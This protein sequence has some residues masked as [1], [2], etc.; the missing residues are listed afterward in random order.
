LSS[1]PRATDPTHRTARFHHLFRRIFSFPAMLACL[2]AMLATLTVR[3]RFND[4]D[5]WWQLK[6][7]EIIWTTHTVPTTDLF[8]Y[9]T[10]H[11]TWVPHEWLSQL[12][13]YGA[14]RWGGYSGL[15][16]WL[17]FFAAALLIAGYTLCSLY[18]GNSKTAFIGAL[19]IWLF[20][21]TV[22]AIRP[23]LVGYL[24]LVFELILV[25]LGRT[26][27]PRW[28]FGL[29]PLFA[30]WV[31]CHGSFFLGLLLLGLFLFCSFFDLRVGLLVSSR[32]D[33]RRRRT[34]VWALLLSTAALFL[35]PVGV[36]Q[37]LYPLNT[38]LRQH[39]V[40]SQISEW[41][42]L[43]YNDPRGAAL[44]AVLGCIFLLVIVRRAELFWQELLMLIMGT[45]LGI[46]HQRLA[47]VFGLLA[48]PIVSR[49]ISTSR[50]SYS[51]EQ[52][53]P[54]PNAVLIT[55]A[56]AT[57]IFTFPSQK[58]LQ[59]QV[60]DGNPVKAVE[61]IKTRHLS[62][63]MLN[64]FDYGGYL[65]WAL[66]EQPVFVDGRA[67]VYEWSGVLEEFAKWATLQSDS[68]ALLDKYG[69]DFCLLERGSLMANVM[70][71][72]PNWKVIYTDDVSV[73]FVRSAK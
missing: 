2:L 65:I 5:T 29:P 32:W 49:L 64:A 36:K 41:M 38:L 39:I 16:L 6:T 43:Q 73:I 44:L 27:D 45:V 46:S 53:H 68:N 22:F 21:T 17:C 58:D 8:S 13:I 61:F 50:D 7:G 24:L 14:Y 20:S 25:H 37:I 26:R 70:P 23:Q 54:L 28:F 10:N 9:T 72:L 3:S 66:P 19:I 60:A 34:F 67:D 30:L 11:H 15:M 63:H 55:L 71:L 51:V 4:T 12:M 62:G 57:V 59:K 42:P 48:A 47:V 33:L 18:S 52:D 40:V 56:L 69:V 1:T 35:N 31:N